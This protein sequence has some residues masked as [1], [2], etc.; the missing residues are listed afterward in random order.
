LV[1]TQLLHQADRFV[2]RVSCRFEFHLIS[3]VFDLP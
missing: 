2:C 3:I 1:F